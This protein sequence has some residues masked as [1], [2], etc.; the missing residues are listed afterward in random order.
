MKQFYYMIV[1]AMR[2]VDLNAL[3]PDSQIKRLIFKMKAENVKLFRFIGCTNE[4][5]D[6]LL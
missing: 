4:V 6:L 2:H 1:E 3:K 5:R